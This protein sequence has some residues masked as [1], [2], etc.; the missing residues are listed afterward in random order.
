MGVQ[1]AKAFQDAGKNVIVILDVDGV[2]IADE[3][4]PTGLTV[5]H[6]SLKEFINNGGRA[7]ACEHCIGS[8]NVDNLLRGVEI[9]P[10]PYMPKLQ[11]IL[12]EADLV[13]DY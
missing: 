2:R 8:F 11:N 10:H 13:L 9:D 5:Q 7:I 6:E 4:R 12:M 3:D 1:H